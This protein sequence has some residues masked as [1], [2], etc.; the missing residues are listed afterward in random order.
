MEAAVVIS[1]DLANSVFR[2]HGVDA[3]GKVVV[4]EHLTAWAVVTVFHEAA[5]VFY[6]N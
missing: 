4:Q 5:F 3:A 6:R 2:V 1:L